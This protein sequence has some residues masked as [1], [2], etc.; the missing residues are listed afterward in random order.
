MKADFGISPAGI[1]YPIEAGMQG[2]EQRIG[3]QILTYSCF[4][5]C[6]VLSIFHGELP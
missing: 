2:S 3:A 5:G 6:R 1:D 4:R